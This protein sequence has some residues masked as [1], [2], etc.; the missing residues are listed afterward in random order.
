MGTS[1]P[2]IK[3][4]KPVKSKAGQ[5]LLSEIEIISDVSF[6]PNPVIDKTPMIREAHKIIEPIREIC[7]PEEV[8]A[9]K[10]LFNPNLKSKPLSRLKKRSKKEAKIAT[11]AAN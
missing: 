11:E 1:I 3:Q 7:F 5:I 8:Q 10:N 9:L 6:T 4:A 2:R